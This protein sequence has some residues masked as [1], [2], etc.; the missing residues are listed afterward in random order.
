MLKQQPLPAE[1]NTHSAAAPPTTQEIA[2]AIAALEA[3]KTSRDNNAV[4]TNTVSE[5]IDNLG[6]DMTADDVLAEVRAQR[7]RQA[8]TDRPRHAVPK[9]RSVLI[10]VAAL[11]F[12]GAVLSSHLTTPEAAP[13]QAALATSF[14]IAP[15]P[16]RFSVPPSALVQDTV[17]HTL[18]VKTWAE[19]PD[20]HA[21]RYEI[22]PNS[23]WTI[24][25]H[26]GKLYV[27]AWAVPMSATAM[28][29]VSSDNGLLLFRESSGTDNNVPATVPLTLAADDVTITDDGY[30][31]R[32]HHVR[33]DSHAHEKWNP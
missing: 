1:Q 20:N 5:I 12:S 2:Q 3:R 16:E 25:K 24:V 22:N 11:T 8:Q 13:P 30:N 6:L 19:I 15:A 21:V 28:G 32:A 26:G 27:R 14:L 31:L 33:L 29:Q 18:T 10:A 17:G 7:A 4:Q 9:W 23:V